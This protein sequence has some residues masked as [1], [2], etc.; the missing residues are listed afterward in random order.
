SV[1]PGRAWSLTFSRPSLALQLVYLVL[2]LVPRLR[3][4]PPRALRA[5]DLGIHAAVGFCFLGITLSY[6]VPSIG[7]Y[8]LLLALTSILTLRALLVPSSPLFTLAVGV[9]TALPGSLGVL[10]NAARYGAPLV[11]PATVRGIYVS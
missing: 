10:G 7:M 3:S 8:A 11:A 5:F 4:F 2:A 1:G 9:V 6:P